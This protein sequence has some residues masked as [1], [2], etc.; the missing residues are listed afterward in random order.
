MESVMVQVLLIELETARQSLDRVF[1]S[2]N[3]AAPEIPKPLRHKTAASGK[4]ASRNPTIKFVT[5]NG[6]TIERVREREGSATDS[7]GGCHFVV[8]GPK[9]EERRVIVAFG[10]AAIGLVQSLQE[11]IPLSLLSPFWLRFAELHLATYLWERND[12]P[13]GGRLIIERLSDEELRLAIRPN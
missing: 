2:L 8:R 5:E 11:S 4:T 10:E 3:P 12:Y 6:F 9:D 13:E 7:A 1:A